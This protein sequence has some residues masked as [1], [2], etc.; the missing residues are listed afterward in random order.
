MA[1]EYLKKCSTSLAMREMKIKTTLRFYLISARMAI[2]KKTYHNKC[3]RGCGEKRA[4][5]TVCGNVN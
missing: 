2:I 4:L 1:I 5:Y 3:W